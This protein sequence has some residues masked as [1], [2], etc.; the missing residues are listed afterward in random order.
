MRIQG[1]LAA[2][3][4]KNDLYVD[5]PYSS[6]RDYCGFSYG[7]TATPTVTGIEP[8]QAS[9]DAT[10]TI[11]GTGF[12]EVLT[13]NYVLFGDVECTMLSA[14]MT[15]I[16]CMLGAGYAGF[17][18]L[19]LHVI[20]AGVAETNAQGLA[21]DLVLSG[22]APRQGSQTGGTEMTI[23]GSGF[24]HETSGIE[25]PPHVQ[26]MS[27]ECVSGWRNEATIGGRPCI[28]VQSTGTSLTVKTPA[29]VAGG[30]GDL[31][32]FVVCL[33]NAN[34]SASVVL[35]N[36]FTY[37]SVFTPSLTSIVPS[38]GAVQG[39]QTVMISGLG[40]SPNVLDNEVLVGVVDIALQ[41]NLYHCIVYGRSS[42][43]RCSL[44]LAECLILP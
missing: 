22:V 15:R 40:F 1:Q 11:T 9:R 8:G 13:E 18:G 26:D 23:T 19:Y 34:I 14:T 2:C 35:A 7:P 30:T 38:M 37:D 3:S 27:T 31:E 4:G 39:G 33:D 29:E 12:S 42:K 21:Y 36:A 16:E 6:H 20:Y 41:N 28:V 32:V 24:Y 43:H 25:L 17:K 10:I 5:I 44:P